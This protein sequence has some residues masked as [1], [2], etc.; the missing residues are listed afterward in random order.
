VKVAISVRGRFWAFDLAR[1]LAREGALQRLITSAPALL[2]E[3]FGVPRG[4]VIGLPAYELLARGARHL[5]MAAD[6]A[7]EAPVAAAF[8]RAAARRIPL[9]PDVFVGWSGSS[10]EGLR[11]AK[12]RGAL[13]VLERGS[14]H[15]ETQDEILGALA[16][17]TGIPL[18]RPSPAVVRREILE[19]QL[20]DRIAVPSDFVAASFV[21]RGFAPE[22]L[23]VNPFGV[24]LAAFTPATSPPLNPRLLCVGRVG[25][26]KGSHVLIDAFLQSGVRGELVFVGP[27]EPEFSARARAAA[28]DRVRF[29]GPVPQAQLPALYQSATAFALPSFEEG[30]AMVILQ[31]MACGLPVLVSDHTGVAGL[32]DERHGALLH[33][34]GDTQTLVAQIERLG[35]APD[36]AREFGARAAGAVARGFTWRDYAARALAAYHGALAPAPPRLAP[37]VR[38]RAGAEV[39]MLPGQRTPPHPWVPPHRRRRAA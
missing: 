36:R 17:H 26:R 35:R 10:L 11:V 20:A 2:A 24:D 34:A 23:I 38:P 6:R 4:L 21:A 3:R 16:E 39:Q 22:R 7:L 25:A 9:Y 14:A 31:A 5:P 18:R 1:E 33:Q 28:S 8:G 37:A 32:F 19:Y 30:L 15:I 13:T 29:L 27:I 12:D